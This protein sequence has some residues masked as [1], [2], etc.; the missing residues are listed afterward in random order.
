[1]TTTTHSLT[2]AM[3]ERPSAVASY[4]HTLGL[5]G[6]VEDLVFRGY[7]QRQLAALSGR[8]SMTSAER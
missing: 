1:M 6:I 5:V 3:P 2:S 4:V 8:I 7:L